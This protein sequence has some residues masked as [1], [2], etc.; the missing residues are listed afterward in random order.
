MVPCFALLL[1]QVFSDWHFCPHT[2]RQHT[3]FCL[4]LA[5]IWREWVRINRET[6]WCYKEFHSCTPSVVWQT[7]LLTHLL[8]SGIGRHWQHRDNM[9]LQSAPFKIGTMSQRA[10]LWTWQTLLR[11]HLL[12][13]GIGTNLLRNWYLLAR[14]IF[15]FTK[16]LLLVIIA[17]IITDD[18]RECVSLGLG[19]LIRYSKQSGRQ[20]GSPWLLRKSN[21]YHRHIHIIIIVIVGYR[22][23]ILKNELKY[24]ACILMWFKFFDQ[25]CLQCD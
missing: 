2:K 19:F 22:K 17:I 24:F 7:L 16:W 5:D 1:L 25:S 14:S 8:L 12:L 10:A 3:C 4:E 18:W 20:T 6:I 15:V 21:Q 13:S 11:K 9:M 23:Q